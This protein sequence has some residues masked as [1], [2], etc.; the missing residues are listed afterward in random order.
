MQ[1]PESHPTHHR[2]GA[3]LSPRAAFR[4]AFGGMAIFVSFPLLGLGAYLIKDQFEDPVGSDPAGLLCAA[5]LIA[6]ALVLLSYVIYPGG[7]HQS[8]AD[9]AEVQEMSDERIIDISVSPPATVRK[10]VPD[11]AARSRRVDTARV[12]P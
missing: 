5:V 4:H 8:R 3:L 6:T 12:R 2:R 1:A 11:L 10:E 7:T 9:S